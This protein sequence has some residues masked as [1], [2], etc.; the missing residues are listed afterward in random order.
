MS[1]T[2]PMHGA[3]RTHVLLVGIDAYPKVAPL[4]GCVNDVDAWETL[5]LDRLG[6]EPAAITK[7]VAPHA[8]I[9]RRGRVPEDKPTSENIRRALE[10]LTTDAVRPGDRVFIHYSGHGTQVLSRVSRTAREALVPV[11]ALD[12]GELLFDDEMNDILR[13]IA[14]RTKDLTVILDACCSAGATRSAFARRQTAIRFCYLNDEVGGDPP[15]VYRSAQ[16]SSGLLSVFDPA[17]PGFLVVASAQ[18]GEP[19]NEGRDAHGVRHGAFTAA[20]L[21]LLHVAPAD[22]LA[23]LAWV[24][25]WQVLR[26]RVSSVFPGQHPCLW[27]RR[28]RRILGGSFQMHDPGIPIA[29]M[30]GKYHL[31]AGTLVGLGPGATVAVYGREPP[32]F[33]TLHSP[34]DRLAQRGL[35]R[36][37]SATVASAIALPVG[38]PVLLEDGARGRLVAAGPADKLVVGLEP[39]DRNLAHYLENEG[40]FRVVSAA[41]P[42]DYEVEVLVGSSSNAQWWIGDV[43]FGADMPLAR[44]HTAHR[45]ALARVLSHYARYVLPLRLVHRDRHGVGTLRL[46]VLD[47]RAVQRISAEEYHDPPLPEAEPDA[48]RR[49]RYHIAD[50]QPVCFSVENRSSFPLSTNVINCSASG[51]VE[52]L[53]PKQLE[54]APKRRQA[55]WL[56]GHLGQP[57]PCSISDGRDFNIE[58][59]V[60]VGTASPHADLSYLQLKESFADAIKSGSRETLPEKDEPRD[61]WTAASVSVLITR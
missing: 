12:G 23:S 28:E 50:R 35:L 60:V 6:L 42:G 57:F 10:S 19:A 37:E 34:E 38:R 44:V 5:F 55:F 48:A 36:V 13:R 9:V 31:E 56:R 33:P 45:D 3:S 59:L 58:R 18:S 26:A 52:L 51:K 29:M 30:D 61:F 39:F 17:D 8:A 54:I 22:K 41:S 49:Y 16:A 7:L 15:Q 46:R 27:G 25:V 14:A 32:V 53:G 40:P 4:H 2:R 43:V 11:D 47:A 24:D 21:D 1:D 20:L